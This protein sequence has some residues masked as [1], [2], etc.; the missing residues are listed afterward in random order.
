MPKKQYSH[1]TQAERCKI[2]ELLQSGISIRSVANYLGRSPS[3]ISREVS[4][5]KVNT[6]YGPMRANRR[7]AEIRSHASQRPRK[8]TPEVIALV[9]DLLISTDASP[10]QISGRLKLQKRASISPET[11]YKHLWADKKR[12]GWLYKRLRHSGKKYRK[13]GSKQTCRELI[14]DRI[15]IEHRPKIVEDKARFGDFELDTIIGAGRNGSLLTI[16]DRCTKYTWISPLKRNTSACV[17]EAAVASLQKLHGR[18]LIHTFTSDN[19]FE[20]YGHKAITRALGGA[21]YFANP[22]CSWER[23]LNEHTNG[24]IRQDLPKSTP[25]NIIS[26]N[27][28]DHIQ[29][30]LNNRPRKSLKYKTPTEVFLELTACSPSVALHT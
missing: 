14:P 29:Q 3:S 25:F 9:M 22:Y 30:K 19:G 26:K 13:R 23:G 1:L 10:E 21:F 11:I 8:M 28:L 16:V 17:A 24:L 27:A 18:G 7:A 5:Y 6:K 15:G 12:G 20:F 2:S 4:Q